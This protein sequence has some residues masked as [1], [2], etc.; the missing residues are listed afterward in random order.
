[1]ILLDDIKRHCEKHLQKDGT[2]LTAL[3]FFE[4]S[5][6]GGKQKVLLLARFLD[7]KLK[8]ERVSAMECSSTG[9]PYIAYLTVS[10]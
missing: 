2:Y 8:N 10:R 1:M 6:I 9:G 7:M 5:E 4:V 3:Q